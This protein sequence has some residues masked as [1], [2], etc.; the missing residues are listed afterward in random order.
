[1][2]EPTSMSEPLNI[3]P[4]IDENAVVE[5]IVPGKLVYVRTV[6]GS[7]PETLGFKLDQLIIRNADGSCRPYRGEPLTDWGLV[8]GSK[9]VVWGIKHTDVRPALVIEADRPKEVGVVIGNTISNAVNV[10]VS[11]TAAT[12]GKFFR[13]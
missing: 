12:I 7:P 6:G 4:G 9:V 10:T 5:R 3:K 2:S 8:S 11:T 1:M 13:H